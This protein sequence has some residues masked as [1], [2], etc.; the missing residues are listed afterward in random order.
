MSYKTREKGKKEINI[1]VRHGKERKNNSNNKKI[2]RA[3]MNI[4]TPW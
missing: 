1:Q 4:S 2:I 3:I